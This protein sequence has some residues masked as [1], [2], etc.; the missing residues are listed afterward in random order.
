MDP[1]PHRAQWYWFSPVWI[2]MWQFVWFVV[3]GVVCGCTYPISFLWLGII[4]SMLHCLLPSSHFSLSFKFFSLLTAMTSQ[5]RSKWSCLKHLKSPLWQCFIRICCV[6]PVSGKF[7]QLH[8][9]KL[10]F[11]QIIHPL[12]FYKSK[13]PSVYVS[14]CLS[15]HFW[16]TV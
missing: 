6:N 15:V 5:Q 13:C 10:Y 3:C 4:F 14:V 11:F 9:A 2:F 1:I 7:V 12:A 8:W 16:G